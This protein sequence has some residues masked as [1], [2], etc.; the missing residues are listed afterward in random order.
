MAFL[1]PSEAMAATFD[2]LY[3]FGDSLSDP[4]NVFNV[5]E[6]TPLIP[7]IPESPPYFEGRYSNGPIWVDQLA[8][9]LDLTP[10]PSTDLAV[11][12]PGFPVRSPI[13]TTPNFGVS[14]FFNGATPNQSVNFAFGGAQT[15]F[16][17]SGDYGRFLPGVLRQ[18]EGFS[19]DLSVANTV[20][21]PRALY[22]I[23]AG[24]N[25]YQTAD[26]P[27]PEA[28][29]G[30]LATAVNSLFNLGAR[31]FLVPNLP[32][33]G[34]TALALERGAQESTRLTNLTNAHNVLLDATLSNLSQ[35]LTDI[36]LVPLDVYSLFDEAIAN[37]A[38]FG[39]TNI[40]QAC[41]DTLIC[42]NPNEYLFW[43][44]IHPTTT[45]HARL[46]EFAL[47]ALTPD[48]VPAI[49]DSTS[50]RALNSEPESVPEP[51]SA[52]SLGGLGLLWVLR[53]R[54]NQG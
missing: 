12:F 30:N 28:S 31:N 20:A 15:G 25:D 43:D 16:A 22:V 19:D 33:L 14:F 47:A 5:T 29:V 10:T 24:A 46:G 23:W 7:T 42:P 51:T 8:K 21:N 2:Q 44:G 39:L 37:P 40:T 45:A 26:N 53:R 27:N 34:R 54:F 50:A 48:L 4:G 13:T 38:A 11:L 36:Q 3:V 1:L 9:A 18:I 35:S 6:F 32:D 52:V 17:G 49:A 41:L